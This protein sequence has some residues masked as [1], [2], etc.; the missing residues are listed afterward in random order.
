MRVFL[1]PLFIESSQKIIDEHSDLDICAL[2][3]SQAVLVED[4]V[5]KELSV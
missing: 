1:C 5:K 3:N 2:N 4:G